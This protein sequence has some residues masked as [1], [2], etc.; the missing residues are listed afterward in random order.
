M[1]E[2]VAEAEADAELAAVAEP[3]A[4]AEEAAALEEVAAAAEDDE[5]DVAEIASAVAFLV[6]HCSFWAQV[7]CP[8]ASFGWLSTH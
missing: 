3:E 7:A 6:P 5:D 4:E 1:P 8:W 2:A